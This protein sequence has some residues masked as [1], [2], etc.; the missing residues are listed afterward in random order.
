MSNFRTEIKRVEGYLK[1]V[2]TVLD[3]SGEPISNVINPLM[4][5]IRRRDIMQ[6][7]IGELFISNP[8]CF[9]EEVWQLIE[10]IKI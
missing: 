4:V 3:D 9:T 1:E 6:I 7:F 8:F 2:V 10:D 5:E